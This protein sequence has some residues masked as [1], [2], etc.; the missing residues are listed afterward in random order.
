[1]RRVIRALAL[2]ATLAAVASTASA[3]SV[4]CPNSEATLVGT[5]V[6]PVAAT[7]D[8]SATTLAGAGHAAYRLPDGTLSMSQCC[9][10]ATTSVLAVD[11]FDASGVAPGTPVAVTVEL[12][13]DGSVST[14]GCGG[15]GCSGMYGARILHGTDST[16]VIHSEAMFSGSRAFHDVLTLPVTIVAGRPEVIRFLLFGHR[17]PGGSHASE[18]TGTYRFPG[19]PAG[20]TVTSCQGYPSPSV[21]ARPTSWGRIKLTYR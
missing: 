7:F 14:L 20:V 6:Y 5:T 21:P 18:G 19:L 8:S 10:L 16:E 3:R 17:N 12:T 13:V 2:L 11:A 4:P 1:M 9:A 15:S